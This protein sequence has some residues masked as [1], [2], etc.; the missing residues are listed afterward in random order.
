MGVIIGVILNVFV[1]SSVLSILIIVH[2]YGHFLVARRN[3]IRV[4]KFAIGFGPPLFRIKG[5]ETEFLICV[6]PLGGYVKL[7]GESR[8]EIKGSNYEFF[9]KPPGIRMRVVLAGPLFNYLLALV[10]FWIIAVVGFTTQDFSQTVVGEVFEFCPSV[11]GE[12]GK[13]TPG[14]NCP[15][16]LAGLQPQDRILEVDG[17]KVSDWQNMKDL[18]SGSEREITLK[19][20]RS[21]QILT[22]SLLVKKTEI[23]DFFGRKKTDA[24]I[25]IIPVLKTEKYNI[26]QGFVRGIEML[27]F[28]TIF[29]LKGFFLI[30]TGQIPFKES[31][32]GI[33]GIYVVTSDAVKK[34]IVDILQLVAVLNVSLA[35]I[36]LVPFPLLDGGHFFIFIMERIR[37]KPISEKVENILTRVGIVILSVLCVLVF[38]NDI[39]KLIEKNSH[40]AGKK[41]K[42]ERY[43]R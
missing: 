42:L 18:I 43:S 33:V 7:A 37:R 27:I 19:V 29:M 23:S 5:K 8:S 41:E 12:G 30:I 9:S 3:G 15:A 14:E 17:Q 32:S 24:I 31:V 4:E 40:R 6:F 39:V 28:S 1:F 16:Y 11:S 36:N 34:G 21:E 2:E 25:G 26:F 35:I 10:T 13:T 22:K 38:Y 20:E